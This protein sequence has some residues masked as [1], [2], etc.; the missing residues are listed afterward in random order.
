MQAHI[1]HT[2]QARHFYKDHNWHYEHNRHG[3]RHSSCLDKYAKE[4]N[5][6]HK[7]VERL[8]SRDTKKH[9][10]TRKGN[11]HPLSIP[12]TKNHRAF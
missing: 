12:L 7:I 5:T 10:S 11:L 4:K 3:S 2:V 6:I 8:S 9:T 1:K